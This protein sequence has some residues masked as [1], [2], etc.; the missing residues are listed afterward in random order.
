MF[1]N[2]ILYLILALSFFLNAKSISLFDSN[3]TTISQDDV[4]FA[5]ELGGKTDFWTPGI[6]RNV[7]EYETEGIQLGFG[8]AKVRLYDNDVFTIERYETF[9]SSKNQSDLLE[10]YKEDEKANSYVDGMRITLQLIKII[11][12]LF[13][14]EWLD[15]LEYEYNTRN[16]VG[17]AT[18]LKNSK[19]WYGKLD[20]EDGVDYSRLE[21]GQNVSFKTKFTSHKL[22][23]RF[24]NILNLKKS[25]AS[26]GI[27]DEEWSKPTFIGDKLDEEYIIFDAN[28]YSQGISANFGFRDKVY[29]IRAY[30]DYGIDNEMKVIQKGDNYSQY[31]QDINVYTM[32]LMG[33]YRFVDVYSTK[34]FNT[35]IIIGATMQY[36]E[37]DVDTIALDAD[38]VYGINAGVEIIF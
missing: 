31:N 13:D 4:K 23:Y 24:D 19:Y 2:K 29:D 37:I 26:I 22:L 11:N 30:F 25:Y 1:K 20:G 18:L 36:N 28:Y 12:F 35:D 14:K 21:V 6:A 38:T 34:M 10:R 9:T 3:E 15:G 17:K 27:F 32:G 33:E 8:K 16:F 7:L 5:I